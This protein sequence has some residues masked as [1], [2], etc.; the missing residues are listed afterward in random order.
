MSRFSCVWSDFLPLLFYFLLL[1]LPLLNAG[2]VLGVPE[3]TRGNRG[4]GS[5]GGG[6]SHSCA[7]IVQETDFFPSH[8]ELVIVLSRSSGRM[9][10]QN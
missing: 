2:A 9:P 10:L 5:H 3:V 4:K 1:F 6:C 7:V 8:K